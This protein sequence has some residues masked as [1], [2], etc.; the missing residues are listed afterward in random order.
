METAIERP[1]CEV[2]DSLV[3]TIVFERA[4]A[5]SGRDCRVCNIFV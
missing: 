5:K 1:R 2:N 4:N 3:A